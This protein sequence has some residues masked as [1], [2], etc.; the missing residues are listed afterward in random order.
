MLNYNG[1]AQYLALIGTVV[2][3]V[4]GNGNGHLDPGETADLTSTLKNIGGANFTNLNTTIQSS[5]P[6]LTITDNTGYFGTLMVDSTKENTSDPYTV[7]ASP[8]AP[9][10]HPALCQ[11]IATE[12]SFADTIDFTLIIG[13]IHYYIWN[14]DPSPTPGEFMH[15]ALASIGYTGNYGVD[16]PVSD[17]YVYSAIFVC[18]GIYANNYVLAATAPEVTAL[19]DYVNNGGRLYLEGGD[20]WYYDPLYQGGYDFGPL[21]GINATADG[22]SDCGPVAGQN[23]T[24]TTGMNFNYSGEN[25]WIDHISPTA[26]GFLIFYDTDNA[27][28]CAVANDAGTYRTVGSSFE[29]GGLVDGSGVSTRAALLDS[30]MNFFGIFVVGTEENTRSHVSALT[31]QTYPN[32]FR[33]RIEIQYT[34]PSNT[35]QANFKIFDAAGRLV[36]NFETSGTQSLIPTTITWNGK[37]ING[38][39]V[40]S[41]VYFIHMEAENQRIVE[42]II[43]VE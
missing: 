29:L 34:L 41:G 35:N 43:L 20:T 18:A 1:S 10:G 5:D 23:N 7:Y 32:P 36:K 22:S 6:Y 37:D 16:L 21:F 33:D 26:T 15:T 17:L 30:I 27:Y 25:A 38:K 42:K 13:R 40:A 28:D 11:L 3:D 9:D 8:S 14:P 24:F 4:G 19:V 31:L 39:Q 12:G 2:D